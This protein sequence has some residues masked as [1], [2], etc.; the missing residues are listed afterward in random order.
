MPSLE[1]MEP[2]SN[3]VE[4]GDPTLIT[5]PDV[6]AEALPEV[7]EPETDAQTDA[8]QG[9]AKPDEDPATKSLKRM[10]R[11]IDRISAARHQA[12][13]EAEMS[14]RQMAELQ[15]RLAQYEQPQEQQQ[16]QQP[17]PQQ[18][19]YDVVAVA[20]ELRA[21]E[22]VTDRSNHVVNEGTKRFPEFAKALQIVAEEVGPLVVPIAPGARVG[23]PTP[24][25]EAIL[26]ADDPAGVL[27]YL[28]AN[29]EVAGELASMSATQAARRILRIE[30][31]L[32]KPKEPKQS[33][34]PKPISPARSAARN[35]EALSNDLPID[36]WA[37]RFYQQMGRR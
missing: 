11:R 24:I 21:L 15:Q 31:E 23:K 4:A 13:A 5:S 33:M 17:Q 6:T 1:T 28:G 25:G 26:D 16:Y 36:E 37:K 7:A 10:E 22:K 34:A 8:E 2:D 12:Q 19:Q 32:S 14:R 3:T 20:Q 35:T 29:P 27:N 30:L 18:Q 9:E